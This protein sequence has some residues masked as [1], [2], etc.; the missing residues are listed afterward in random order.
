MSNNAHRH[1]FGLAFLALFLLFGA[2]FVSAGLIGFRSLGVDERWE[3]VSGVVTDVISQRED[4]GTL[5][6][7]VVGYEVDGRPY[8]V[9]SRSRSSVYPTLGASREVAYN[10]N[11]PDQAKL[12]EGVGVKLFFLI[13]LLVGGMFVVIGPTFFLQSRRRSKVIE[14]LVHSGKKLQGVL[15]EVRQVG[16]FNKKTLYKV[17]VAAA[18]THGS[19][20]NYESDSVSGIG[21]L[22][23]VDLQKTPVPVDVFLD[24]I[25]PG[26]F[27]VDVSDLPNLTPH[28]LHDLISRARRG[29]VG[30]MEL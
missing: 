17:V 29:D 30:T 7:P 22:L 14:H 2:A 4:E 10:P 18:D 5:Y 9:A 8:E 11:R 20:K 21:G 6:A 27:Y 26:Q 25:D 16:S 15:I 24:P 1:K 23:M 13:F 3:R 19:V 28:N 12:V